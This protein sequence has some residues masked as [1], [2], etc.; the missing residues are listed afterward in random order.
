[1]ASSPAPTRTVQA[2]APVR[3]CDI[4][5]WTDTW[6]AGHGVVFHMAV[7]PGVEVGVRV[8]H[9]AGSG[10]RVSLEAGHGDAPY[11]FDPS[12]PP[13]RQ[14][15]LEATIA[16]V[17]LPDDVSVQV[18]VSSGVP[19]GS[20][21]GTSAAVTVALIGALDLVAGRIRASPEVAA[22]AH[23]VETERLG[24]E[25]GVQ[26]QVCAAY[27][28]I[29]YVEIPSYPETRVTQLDVPDAIWSGL[30]R[31]LVLVSLG[32][33]HVSSALHQRVIARLRSDRGSSSAEL[34]VLRR[35]A[36]EAK[37]AVELGD[38]ERLGRAM[39]ENTEAQARLHPDLV[40]ADAHRL[41]RVAAAQGA[42]GWKVNGAGGDGGS[43]TLLCGSDPRAKEGL[44]E[45]LRPS[46]TGF[47]VIP[48]RL[49]REG[50]RAWES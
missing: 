31:R 42:S 5:G 48:I 43:V 1:V 12:D 9:R 4:G 27:G 15:L 16:E 44:L 10:G 36:T 28:G 11:S 32:R 3:I 21:T 34:E 26:D 41:I 13:G 18:A 7:T 17:G 14:P 40:S 30:D 20:A 29:N 35:A 49:S 2:T 37:A 38:L 6:F 23:R 50:L 25:S 19:A 45:A 39:V 47:D 33:P 46:G 8:L 22:L 24:Q